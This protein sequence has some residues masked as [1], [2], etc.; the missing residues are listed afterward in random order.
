MNEKYINEIVG[1][2]MAN[3]NA[4]K[5]S[6]HSCEGAVCGCSFGNGI[7]DNMEQAVEACVIAQREFVKM[8][9][10]FRGVVADAIKKLAIDEAPLLAKMAVEETGLG[11]YRDK[12]IKNQLVG[13]KT[14]GIEDLRTESW[15][16]DDGLSLMELSPFGV[17]GAITPTTNPSETILCN[18]IGM[19][20]AGNGAV[21][22]PHPM[23][24]EVSA[25]TVE[26]INQVIVK[27]GGPVNL[28]TTVNNPTMAQA[29][30]L[31]AHPKV[32]MLVATGGPGVVKAVLASGK[33]AI[34]AGAGN[35]P[36]I[37]DESAD[38][39]KAAKDIV[40]GAAF[41]NNV[42]CIAEKEVF[43]LRNIA[44]YLIFQM[45]ANGAF[46]VKNPADLQKLEATVLHNGKP[47]KD[48]VGKDAD[49]IL[50]KAGI[51]FTGD[52]RLIIVETDSSH[53]FVQREMLMPVLPVVR[54]D[55][56]DQ[57]IKM[58][59]EAE[60]GYKH[61]AI[62]HSK[63]INNLTNF[64]KAIQTSIFVKNGPSYAGLGVGGE[65]YTTYTIAGPTG[66]GLTST[67]DFVRRRRC[68]LV[69]DFNIR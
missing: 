13:E 60:H 12:I 29:N 20:A 47:N 54:A 57:A 40:D 67:R 34:G 61:T 64:A 22:S 66:E 49:Y 48:F 63:N 52:V 43:A 2:V 36:V 33:K 53:P 46:L 17:I 31:I 27:C 23:A 9:Y 44:D 14:P 28:V 4:S 65:G 5:D 15:T 6:S 58:A 30:I 69:D 25:K 42:L 7:F 21:F 62:I 32:D 11:R 8:P 1:K 39:V 3:L 41:D 56:I 59:I 45:Q 35:P 26:L 50:N 16:G 55:N 10:R 37:V 38:I 19:L 51:S 24:K 18:T 68:V